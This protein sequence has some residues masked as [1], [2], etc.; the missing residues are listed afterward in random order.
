LLQH[1]P[2]FLITSLRSKEMSLLIDICSILSILLF[3]LLKIF[4]VINCALNLDLPTIPLFFRCMSLASV[5]NSLICFLSF[6]F[7]VTLFY[8]TLMMTPTSDDL[9]VVRVWL[10]ADSKLKIK[11]KDPKKGYI[12]NGFGR[13]LKVGA[14]LSTEEMQAQQSALSKIFFLVRKGDGHQG[15]IPVILPALKSTAEKTYFMSELCPVQRL[16]SFLPLILLR[17]NLQ[18]GLLPVCY[19]C[20]LMNCSKWFKAL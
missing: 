5:L 19:S 1:E 7:Y 20:L 6:T 11:F 12:L 4:F 3:Q 10:L 14:A 15:L 13:N 8:F 9:P 17:T 18:P 2:Q 16:L